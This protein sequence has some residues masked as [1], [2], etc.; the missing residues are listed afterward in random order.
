MDNNLFQIRV[1]GIL[2]EADRLLLVK[3]RVSEERSWSLPGG[4]VERG[5]TLREA[6]LREMSEETGLTVA[7]QKLLYVCD[8]PDGDPPL[9]HITFLLQRQGGSL[10]LP[11]NEFD[12][13]PISDV[14]WVPIE[15]LTE[16]G[17]SQCF[18]EI[19]RNGFPESGSYRGLKREIGL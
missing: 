11:S 15:E 6:I 7:I 2:I 5:E 4:R 10:Q 9:L 3:Q 17:F 14:V 16:Y 13:N 18:A 8:K 12:K 1:T 19:I